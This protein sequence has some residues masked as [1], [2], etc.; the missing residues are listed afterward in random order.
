MDIYIQFSDV[1]LLY[2]PSKE[3]LDQRVHVSSV[4]TH[5]TQKP[6]CS[7]ATLPS[8]KQLISDPEN[9]RNKFSENDNI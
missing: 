9:T 5:V 1:L 3:C 2:R 4:L 6:Q 7:P 8:K